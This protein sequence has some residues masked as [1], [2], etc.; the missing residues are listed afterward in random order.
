[1]EA[2]YNHTLK[3][4]EALSAAR[5]QAPPAEFHETD[6][7]GDFDLSA[8]QLQK[9]P[10]AKNPGNVDYQGLSGEE[11]EQKSPDMHEN[12]KK[13]P[14]RAKRPL[15]EDEVEDADNDYSFLA[16]FEMNG[17]ELEQMHETFLKQE[18]EK[19]KLRHNNEED[20]AR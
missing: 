14:G 17:Q 12:D 8:A 13:M 20:G 1:M 3:S 4:K 9:L 5:L 6:V 2:L 15:L 19:K 18:R 10:K 16:S 11:E 7:N